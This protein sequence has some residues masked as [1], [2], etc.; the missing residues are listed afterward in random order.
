MPLPMGIWKTNIN[1]TEGQLNINSVDQNGNLQMMFG[2]ENVPGFWDEVSQ[3]ITFSYVTGGNPP[4]NPSIALFKGY[5][6]RT[7]VNAQEGE[8][9]T[10]ILTGFVQLSAGNSNVVFIPFSGS[11]RRNIFG[12]MAQ[13]HEV[14]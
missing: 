13:I 12:W 1:G 5:L 7:P 10:A 6:F 9:L 8:D 11:S 4:I 14:R 3:T 2:G